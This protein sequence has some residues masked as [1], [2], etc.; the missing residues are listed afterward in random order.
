VSVRFAPAGSSLRTAVVS[1]ADNAPLS[2]QGVDVDG[3][4]GGP[5]VWTP[6]GSLS[7]ARDSASATLL[8]DG[9]VLI[10]GGETGEDGTP[11][12][13]SEVYDPTTGTFAPTG[14]LPVTATAPAGVRLADGDVLLAGG[15]AADFTRLDAAEVYDPE[16][17]RWTAI[18]P[19]L[20]VGTHLSATLLPN[21]DALFTGYDD[22]SAELYDPTTGVWSATGTMAATHYFDFAVLLPD[23]LVLVEGGGSAVAELYDPA[24]NDWTATGSMNVAR[25]GATASLLPDGDVVAEG[26]NAPA[27]GNALASAELYDPSTGVWTVTD[28]LPE[29][30]DGQSATLLP[31]GVVL[32]AGGCGASCGI[33]F[34]P[35]SSQA[36]LY[37]DG[38]WGQTDSMTMPRSLQTAT[39][40]ENGDVLVAG[41]DPEEYGPATATAEIYTP[42][43]LSVSPP[44]GP[45]GRTITL[46]G[47]GYY[48]GERVSID[49]NGGTTI[50]TV[51]T[52]PA[53]TFVT[54]VVVPASTV[55]VHPIAADGQR[56]FAQGLASFTVTPS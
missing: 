10:A 2:P 42:V 6:T 1:I 4:G 26:G 55:G 32:A 33:D 54:R 51:T 3:Y 5:N 8:A 18:A 14:S 29:A 7:T 15:A 48:A 17:G 20:E 36:E 37:N 45:V 22:A 52:T 23:G 46:R 50:A 43:L 35:N 56:S 12:A 44:S 40:L 49:W 39:L 9:A 27:N 34:R 13:S 30:E 24:T 47:S 28:A 38:F 16:T 41:G 21:G 25:Y 11:L 53:G 19:M 31:N